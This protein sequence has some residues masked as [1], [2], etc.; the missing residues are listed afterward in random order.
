MYL[1]HFGLREPPFSI[2]PDPAFLYMSQKHQ[3]ALGHLLF[4]TGRYG[5][6]VLLTGEVGTG[7]TTVI[8]AL[9]AQRLDQVNLAYIHN[10]RQN[11]LELV[12]TLC[13][14]LGVTYERPATLKTLT[15][16]LNRF[17]IE[18]HQGGRRTVV[19]IDEAQQ[20]APGVLEQIRLLTNLETTKEKLL[21]VLLVG[22]PE[23]NDL[24]AR[25]DLRQLAQRITARY[26]IVPLTAA[27]VGEYIRHRLRVA[28]GEA[29]TFTP[30]AV[31]E[32][33]RLSG[34]IARVVNVVCDR[35]LTGAYARGARRVDLAMVRL[36]AD[37]TLGLQRPQPLTTETAEPAATAPAALAG[38]RPDQDAVTQTT[39]LF[40]VFVALGLLI[41]AA[42]SW[43]ALRPHRA[44]ARPIV[45]AIPA[46]VAAPLPAPVTVADTSAGDAP[47]GLPGL[48]AN[49]PVLRTLVH[50][51]A[52]TWQPGLVLPANARACTALRAQGLECLSGTQGTWDELRRLNLPAV[53]TLTGPDGRP[54]HALL[55]KLE[56]ETAELLVDDHALAVPVTALEP[57][58]SGEYLVLWRRLTSDAIVD[59]KATPASVRWVRQRLAV[60]SRRIANADDTDGT[61]DDALRRAV[62][63]F[64]RAHGITDG[65][66]IAGPRTLIA[67]AQT[68]PPTVAM[69]ALAGRDLVPS[70]AVGPATEGTP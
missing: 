65:D 61:Y 12:Q 23:V 52:D 59:P 21:R 35:A 51:L 49:P 44:P 56:G 15:D 6:F 4:G 57:L 5:G 48:L 45:A 69:P 29:D 14:E 54:A 64:Q 13:D 38:G 55:R 28:G 41:L 20:L 24:L 43:L 16:G 37:E 63:H 70:G 22:Q 34:G 66:G 17:L 25:P 3:E 19:V 36:A 67:L 30:E 32:V 40:W 26:H 60:A 68:P 62:E 2:T 1:D 9:L 46:P 8:R 18:A 27:E 33:T 7:K 53:L 42:A 11:E 50:T 39:P 31:A 10:P 47:A 58:W